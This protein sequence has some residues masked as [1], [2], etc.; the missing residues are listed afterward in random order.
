LYLCG[1]THAG[2]VCLPGRISLYRPSGCRI[3]M[4]GVWR[5]GDMHGYTSAGAGTSML[6]VR[7][8]CPPEIARITLRRRE[9]RA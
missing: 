6:P 8:N 7:F 2:Q 5:V 4:G 1:H 9:P 3:R